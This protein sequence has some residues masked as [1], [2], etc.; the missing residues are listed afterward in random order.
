MLAH[1]PSVQRCRG[2]CLKN[3]IP[4]IWWFVIILPI[5][6][7]VKAKTWGVNTPV[8][9]PNHTV[10]QVSYPMFIPQTSPT[11]PE[12]HPGV[13]GSCQAAKSSRKA[14][15]RVL[16][17]A[18]RPLIMSRKSWESWRCQT[19]QSEACNQNTNIIHLNTIF[20]NQTNGNLSIYQ[21]IILSIYQCQYLSINTNI[22]L[23]IPVS[24]YL[25][26][27]LSICLSVYLCIYLSVC[28]STYVSIYLSL[29]LCISISLS[30]SLSI[31]LSLYLSIYLSIYPS[32]Y[33]SI[34]RSAPRHL[35]WLVGETRGDFR[36]WPCSIIPLG[37][38]GASAHDA[39]W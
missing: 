26:I 5:S 17:P 39:W 31:S 28:L 8:S 22:Y 32:I 27:Y 3:G 6:Y 2:A 19:F 1:A 14:K 23:S 7:C 11:S 9:N 36:A 38:R 24:I 20:I 10:R 37:T 29:S 25:S 33:L 13:L 15:L 4:K 35:F 12:D 30:L 21:C 34:Y 16:I 18:M